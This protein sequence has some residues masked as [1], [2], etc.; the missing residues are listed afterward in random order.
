MDPVRPGYNT[1]LLLYCASESGTRCLEKI[2]ADYSTKLSMTLI[3]SIV[4]R[5]IYIYVQ[6]QRVFVFTPEMGKLFLYT[7]VLPFQNSATP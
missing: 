5:N 2:F 3:L 1:V 7:L 6:Y 4:Y